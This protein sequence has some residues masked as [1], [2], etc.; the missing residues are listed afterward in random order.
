MTGQPGPQARDR[1]PGARHPGEAGVHW[2]SVAVCLARYRQN[3]PL[4]RTC[5][6]SVVAAVR[7]R[8]AGWRGALFFQLSGPCAIL[9]PRG[10]RRPLYSCQHR[11]IAWAELPCQSLPGASIYRAVSDLLLE[12]VTPASIDVAVEVF[13]E[14]CVPADEGGQG[15]GEDDAL[16]E[17]SAEHGDVK[18]RA[19]RV[20]AVFAIRRVGL[21]ASRP[22]TET[23]QL[24]CQLGRQTAFPPTV[25]S[26]VCL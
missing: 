6:D 14:G 9:V 5:A 16:A 13:E 20:I 15:L 1:Q 10:H 23:G 3:D 12:T 19:S 26:R 17:V 25:G 18:P 11:T 22:K 8:S 24:G 21:P 7:R 2:Y 4:A